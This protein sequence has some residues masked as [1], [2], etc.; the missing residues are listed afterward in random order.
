MREQKVMREQQMMRER[1][2]ITIIDKLDINF[3]FSSGPITGLLC[4][5]LCMIHI[6]SI[7]VLDVPS[8]TCQQAA[9][10]GDRDC[11]N[12]RRYYHLTIGCSLHT[13]GAHA[14]A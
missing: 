5:K 13:G 10:L 1:E 7:V 12:G 4:S 11:H 14:T 6:Q 8:S 2:M 3:V 9:S